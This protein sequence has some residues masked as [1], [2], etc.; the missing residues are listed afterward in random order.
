MKLEVRYFYENGQ[1]MKKGDLVY[2]EGQDENR[3]VYFSGICKVEGVFGELFSARFLG[4][5]T[6]GPYDIEVYVDI[7]DKLVKLDSKEID[8]ALGKAIKYL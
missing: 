1:E 6:G 7:I 4:Q 2:L 3:C 8:E 5:K